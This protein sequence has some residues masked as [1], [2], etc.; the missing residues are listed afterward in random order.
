[1][2][3]TAKTLE[4]MTKADLVIY[5]CNEYNLSLPAKM[6]KADMIEAIL[7][8]KKF[9]KKAERAAKSPSRT[10]PTLK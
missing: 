10:E 2:T 5:A 4:K 3:K 1:M 9:A 6:L 7:A 8:A